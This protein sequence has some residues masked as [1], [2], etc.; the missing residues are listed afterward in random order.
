MKKSMKLLSLLLALVMVLGLAACNSSQNPGASPTPAEGSSRYLILDNVLA[1]EEYGIGFRKNDELC[2]F[3]DAA[4]KVL[5][6]DGKLAEISNQWF[7]EDITTIEADAK[8]LDELSP[9]PR[10]FI[11]GLDDSFPPMGYRD[12]E[13]NIV[14][15]DIDVATA[16]C[17]KLGWT[18]TLKPIDWN[19]KEMELE[20]GNVDCLWNGMTLTDERKETFSCSAPYMKNKQIIVVM[21]D[22][23]IKTMDDLKGKKLVLQ[24]GSSAEEALDAN[25]DFKASLGAVNT[26]DTNLNCFMDLEQGSSDAVLVDSIVADWYITTGNSPE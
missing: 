3:V 18:L 16:V 24:T 15:F 13:N 7:G 23:G 22:S 8:A 6:A 20:S 4:L 9:E 12:S 10:E 14:G 19:A 25:A 17:E 2:T 21:A 11:L 26:M 1:E 5:K